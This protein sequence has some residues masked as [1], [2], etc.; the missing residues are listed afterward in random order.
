[1]SLL[2]CARSNWKHLQAHFDRIIDFRKPSIIAHK[3][4]SNFEKRIEFCAPKLL[5]T[6]FHSGWEIYEHFMALM[7]PNCEYLTHMAKMY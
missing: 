5:Y 4:G 7:P 3:Y 1:M 6:I 2:L